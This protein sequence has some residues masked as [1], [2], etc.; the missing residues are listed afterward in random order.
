MP[1]IQVISHDSEV[2]ERHV[3]ELWTPGTI[4]HRPYAWRRRFETLVHF[5]IAARVQ[6]DAGYSARMP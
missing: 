5:D 2:V 1:T 3:R 6:V 4:T